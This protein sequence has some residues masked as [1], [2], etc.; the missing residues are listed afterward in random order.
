MAQVQCIINI[1]C[2]LCMGTSEHY[3]EKLYM[4]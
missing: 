4:A 1:P 3:I 2:S